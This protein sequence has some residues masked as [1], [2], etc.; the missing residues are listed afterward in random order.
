MENE[1]EIQPVYQA[2]MAFENMF[3]ECDKETFDRLSMSATSDGLS[4]ETRA[5]Y[6]SEAFDSLKEKL[7]KLN[8]QYDQM[9]SNAE[10][11]TQRANILAKVIT[12]ITQIVTHDAE[13]KHELLNRITD[14]LATNVNKQ[15]LEIEK[16]TDVTWV[17]FTSYGQVNIGDKLRFNI[18]DRIYHE[19][20]KLILNRG[21]NNEE[22]VYNQKRNFYFISSMVL[23]GGSNHKNVEIMKS[24]KNNF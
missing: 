8:E 23:S 5:L 9:K 19:R 21:T 6:S 11:Q 17:K 20:V 14:I 12:D 24:I 15:I 7:T 18:G 3:C 4:I 10:A 22:V 13:T 1:I 16:K 2:K